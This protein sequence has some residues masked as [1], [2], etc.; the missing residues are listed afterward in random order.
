MSVEPATNALSLLQSL[1][2]G[3]AV[4]D[5]ESWL[6]LFENARFFDWFPAPGD[7]DA[8]LTQRLPGFDPD[9]VLSR[10]ENNRPFRFETETRTEGRKRSHPIRVTVTSLGEGESRRLLIE[11][12]DIAKQKQAEYMLDSYSKMAERHAKELQKEKDRVEKLLLNIM[13]RPVYEELKD[14]GTTTPHRFDTAS[15]LMLDFVRFTDMTVSQDPSALISELNDI[16][17]AFD[18]I[19]EMFGCERIRTIGDSY[20]AVSGIPE[21]SPDHAQNIA[22]VALR[23][24]RYLERRNAAHPQEWRCRIGIN[25]GPVIGSLVG[26]QKYVYD[27]FGPGVNL[28]ARMESLSEPM[29]ITLCDQ[30]YELLKDEFAMSERGEFQVKGFGTRQLYF[31]E[32]ELKPHY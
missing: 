6:V 3:V 29:Q 24:R 10:L 25:S 4:T 8:P 17:S 18:R 19:A 30:T 13:P 1:E 27:L 21:S 7:A 28:A 22:K 14:Y 15:I 23:M 32:G 16:F 31:L 5:P 11:C 12:H 20:M 2:I 26:I 9:K